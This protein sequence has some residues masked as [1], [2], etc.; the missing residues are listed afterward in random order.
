[1]TEKEA[2]KCI[3][4][5]ICWMLTDENGNFFKFNRSKI[6]GGLETG[7]KINS[8]IETGLYKDFFYCNKFNTKEEAMKWL[9]KVPLKYKKDFNLKPI[10]VAY[11]NFGT[12][13][14]IIR[15]E[16]WKKYVDGINK[17]LEDAK[18]Y[19]TKEEFNSSQDYL[20]LGVL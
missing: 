4:R 15:F 13:T 11:E 18:S 17:L 6:K 2:L 10:K 9:E 7:L 12:I 16:K 14:E 8:S 1:M 20:F 5:N 3:F 19:E